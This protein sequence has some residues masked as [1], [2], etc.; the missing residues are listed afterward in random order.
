MVSREERERRYVALREAM[1]E[2]GH[3]AW[4][5]AGNA[6]AMQRGYIRYVSDWRLWVGMDT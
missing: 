1:E 2:A 6:E 3:D 5:M 4:I